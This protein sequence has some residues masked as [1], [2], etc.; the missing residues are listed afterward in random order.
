ME[1]VLY[2]YAIPFGVAFLLAAAGMYFVLES[3]PTLFGIVRGAPITQQP[4][5]AANQQVFK[6]V[7]QTVLAIA[8]LSIAAFGYGTYKI[9]SAQI[10]DRVRKRTD[11]RYQMSQAHQRTALG[12]M[13]WMLYENS[14]QDSK[15]AKGYLDEAIRHTRIA[16]K[17]HVVELDEKDH[18]VE[19]LI[20][21]IRN[22]LAYYASEKHSEFGGL[23]QSEQGQFLSF[24][25]WIEERINNHPENASDYRDTINTV[26]KRFKAS[27]I[28][29]AEEPKNKA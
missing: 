9:L 18:K 26:R 28:D 23:S 20:C 19:R 25:D 2:G 11:A 16:F 1:R 6:D 4:E 22:N 12:Y 27:D 8:A 5:I 13:N 10:E 14:K 29:A 24:I 7:L 17:D 15:I 21:D 3:L